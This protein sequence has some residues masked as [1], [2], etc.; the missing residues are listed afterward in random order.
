MSLEEI[1]EVSK[2][3]PPQLL[4][5]VMAFSMS[6]LRVFYD[7]KKI[8]IKTMFIEAFICGGL[9]LAVGS[10]I[11]AMGL[12]YRWIFFASGFI[13]HLG[14]DVVRGLSLTFIKRNMK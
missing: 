8:S 10:A 13:G 1:V 9:S 4:G 3:I 6:L 5:I 11:L 7:K 2:K 14:S 12:D